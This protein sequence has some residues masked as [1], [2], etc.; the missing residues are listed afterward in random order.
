MEDAQLF[1]WSKEQTVAEIL[2][3]FSEEQN[4]YILPRHMA[5]QNKDH[6]SSLP[7]S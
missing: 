6:L 2:I 7:Y 3:M 1:V 5:A 4:L